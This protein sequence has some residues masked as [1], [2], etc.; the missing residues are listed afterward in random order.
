M[1]FCYNPCN[2]SDRE[3]CQQCEPTSSL[4]LEFLSLERVMLDDLSLSSGARRGQHGA[5][6]L[7]MRS[8]SSLLVSGGQYEG[9]HTDI[10]VGECEA[11]GEPV[12]CTHVFQLGAART[13]ERGVS[14]LIISALAVIFVFV[15]VVGVIYMNGIKSSHY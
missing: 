5:S 12:N 1:E 13:V 7:K 10:Q 8:V 9:T 11:W 3:N 6:S 15:A 2:G 4:A 14:G